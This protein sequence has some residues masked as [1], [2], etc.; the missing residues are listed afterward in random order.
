MEEEEE[1]AALLLNLL[2][3]SA[4]CM[5]PISL[6]SPLHDS[7]QPGTGARGEEIQNLCSAA[8]TMRQAVVS[9]VEAKYVWH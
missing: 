3:V 4:A 2:M 1:C 9:S 7:R 5:V 8:E 6:H